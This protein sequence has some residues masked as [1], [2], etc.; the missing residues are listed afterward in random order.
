MTHLALPAILPLVPLRSWA[1]RTAGFRGAAVAQ[2]P[3]I[4]CWGLSVRVC[5]GVA[6]RDV[7]AAPIYVSLRVPVLLCCCLFCYVA[8][9][10]VC[11]W[12]FALLSCGVSVQL[13]SGSNGHP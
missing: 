4:P 11:M 9:A 1:R 2:F 7:L 5:W 3:G 8:A 13:Y 6:G 10:F 12:V